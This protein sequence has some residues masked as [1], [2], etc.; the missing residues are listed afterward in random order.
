MCVFFLLLGFGFQTFADFV[1]ARERKYI[2]VHISV[3]D[4]QGFERNI[5]K[6][7][8]SSAKVGLLVSWCFEPSQ[9]QRITSGLNTNFTLYPSHSIH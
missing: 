9:P 2:C 6:E 8:K 3:R 4:L 1:L 7:F 5:N